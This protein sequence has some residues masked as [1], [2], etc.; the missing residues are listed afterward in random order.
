MRQASNILIDPSYRL[1]VQSV[2][3]D[4]EFVNVYIRKNKRFDFVKRSSADVIAVP[5]DSE[6]A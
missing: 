3:S 6:L 2:T 1:S 5:I 4:N